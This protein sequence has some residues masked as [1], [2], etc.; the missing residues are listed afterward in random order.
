M[1]TDTEGM[2][3]TK[4]GDKLNK[5]ILDKLENQ[6]EEEMK[7]AFYD[8]L[9]TKFTTDSKLDDET[10]EWMGSLLQE[11]KDRILYL[12]KGERGVLAGKRLAMYNEIDE[13]LDVSFFKQRIKHAAFEKADLG[14]LVGFTLAKLKD[15]QSSYRDALLIK[16][17]NKLWADNDTDA[18][19]MGKAFG[20]FIRAFHT[21]M[22]IVEKDLKFT[23][24]YFEKFNCFPE[25]SVEEFESKY[26]VGK[27]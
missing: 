10:V 22:D 20:D 15:L 25:L 9:E 13:G 5:A 12:I 27:K 8:L 23:L 21:H 4:E 18:F 7:R 24:L 14:Q 1:S 3:E 2:S 19:C 6:I 16:V 17:Q 11:V 26:S